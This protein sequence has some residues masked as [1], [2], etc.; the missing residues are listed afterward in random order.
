MNYKI[1]E[2][3]AKLGDHYARKLLEERRTQLETLPVRD[4]LGYSLTWCPR[5]IP[6]ALL[7]EIDNMY[8]QISITA[9]D[10]EVSI[11][12]ESFSSLITAQRSLL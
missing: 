7:T 11:E 2:R 12:E 10:T 5:A 9:I 3:D 1:L 6:S 8:R 4:A